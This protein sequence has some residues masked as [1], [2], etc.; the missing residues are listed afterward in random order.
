MRNKKDM[1]EVE[2]KGFWGQLF[3]R[4]DYESIGN[5]KVF[6]N[7]EDRAENLPSTVYLRFICKKC[8]KIKKIEM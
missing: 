8:A 3:C 6:N 4:H 5:Q 2:I 1:L 7:K